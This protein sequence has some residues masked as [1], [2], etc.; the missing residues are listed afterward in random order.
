MKERAASHKTRELHSGGSHRSIHCD[1][2]AVRFLGQTGSIDLDWVKIHVGIVFPFP[3]IIIFTLRGCSGVEEPARRRVP[4]NLFWVTERKV[5]KPDFTEHDFLEC[6]CDESIEFTI[7]AYK[8]GKEDPGR[9]VVELVGEDDLVEV[10]A[11][12]TYGR[13]LTELLINRGRCHGHPLI[14][15][16]VRTLRK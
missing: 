11:T 12:V 2:K 14:V 10:R 6:G 5:R 16:C 7:A 4:P 1:E 13:I 9:F 8:D 15:V 3:F